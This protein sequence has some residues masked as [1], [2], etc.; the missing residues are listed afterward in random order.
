MSSIN[1]RPEIDG[2]RTVAIIP[3]ILFHLRKDLLPGG[4][5]GVDVFF[6]ISGFLITSLILD[7]CRRD[8]FSFSNFWLR[9]IRRILPA[10]IAMVLSTL[11]VGI[12]ML[13][14]GDI[15]NLGTQ[16]IASLLSYANISHW[17]TAGNYWGSAA[18][19]SP[20]LHTWSLSVEEQFYLFFPLFLFVVF[21]FFRKWI[22]II[23]FI[24][25]LLSMLTYFIGTQTNPTATF[26]LLPTRAW[27][28]GV[29]ALLSVAMP[30]S[31]IQFDQTRFKNNLT[32]SI[33]GVFLVLTSYFFV[34]GEAGSSIFAFAPVFGTALLIAFTS[35]DNN[36]LNSTLSAPPVVYIGKI[37]YSLYLWH[38]PIL[39]FL[40]QLELNKN[41]VINPVVTL[42]TIFL[43]SALSYHLIEVPTRRNKRVVPYV[44]AVLLVGVIFSYYLKVGNFAEDTSCYNKTEWYGSLYSVSPDQKWTKSEKNKMYGITVA[45]ND[46]IDNNAYASGGIKRI[47]GDEKPDIV[48]LGD[49]HAVMWAK[50]LDEIAKELSTSISF[51]AA[52]GTPTFFEIP[53]VRKMRGTRFFSA[54]EKFVYDEARLKYITEWKPKVVVI[55]GRWSGVDIETTTDLIRY[56]GSIGSKVLLIEQPP[57]LYFG[58]KNTPQY[59]AYLGVKPKDGINQYVRYSNS[60]TYRAGVN[61]VRQIEKEND[62][63]T[64]VAISDI[65]V[66]DEKA[67]VL[68][69]KDVLYMDDD[70]LSYFGTLKAKNRIASALK[71]LL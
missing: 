57:E 60:S 34:S 7:E 70:H 49:S 33:A 68:D 18:E 62:F 52:D 10:L 16:G 11:V 21:K 25:T 14:P 50:I 1:Y 2:L 65:Y 55:V 67:W 35:N 69:S 13:Y 12:I 3:V 29:G 47:Y 9:R 54:N 56:I 48:V 28:M 43:I 71:Q 15:N 64:T 46:S 61:L 4:Y 41:I 27:E 19:D 6:V 53:P 39:F 8:A 23:F 31:R 51:Y 44:L 38:W 59:L 26:Y 42:V 30:K 32:F 17:L 63:C 5:L 24:L 58:D 37:S 36:I 22:G 66:V 40:K 20:F 45:H